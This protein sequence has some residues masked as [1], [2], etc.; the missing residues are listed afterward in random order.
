MEN[1][2]LIADFMGLRYAEDSVYIDTL[3]E[4]KANGVYF[5]QGYMASELKYDTDWDWLMAVVEKIESL[6]NEFFIV[7]SRCIIAHN[8]DKS[9][10]TIIYF[11]NMGKKIDACYDSVVQ[12]IKW[13]NEQTKQK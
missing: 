5:E 4:M 2:K 10:E 9:I 8:T 6:G 1:N 3:K 13:Y 11:E 7:E 12:F